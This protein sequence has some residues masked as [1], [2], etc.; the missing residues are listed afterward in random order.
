[1][2]NELKSRD[3]NVLKWLIRDHSKSG[4]PIGSPRLVEMDYFDVGSA[5]LR[6]ILH[7]LE[8]SGFLMQPHTSSGRVPTQK[9]YRYFVDRLMEMRSPSETIVQEYE[10]GISRISLDLDTLIR[11]TA[12]FLGDVSHALILMSKPHE[13]VKTIKSLNLHELDRGKVLLIVNTSYDQ[14]STFAFE[15]ESALSSIVL[16]EAEMILND[17]FAGRALDDIK[18]MSGGQ[19]VDVARKNPLVSSLLDQ[20]P[21]LHI[22]ARPDSYQVYGTH[23]LMHYNEITDPRV[24]ELL[25]ESLETNNLQNHLPTPIE[26]GKPKFLIGDELGL[27]GLNRLSLVSIAYEGT[28]CTGEIHFIGP[29]RMAYEKIVSLATFTA[30]K[31]KSII[32]L[33]Y[34]K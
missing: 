34:V 12:Q 29:N 13:R 27:S 23:Q 5:T 10:A 31:M 4:Q 3:E 16:K 33:D 30:E 24:M 11:N 2:G 17:L 7:G 14:V 1:M 32:Q 19:D 9:G 18:K 20:I 6:N 26:A 8:Q 21:D 22:A 15:F 28:E 25:L